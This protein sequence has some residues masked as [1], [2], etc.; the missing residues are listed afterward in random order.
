LAV[1]VVELKQVLAQRASGVAIVTAR[2]GDQ[3]HGMTV[4]AFAEVSLAPPLVLVCADKISH[5][6]SL[7]ARGGVFAL[8]VLAADQRALSDLFASKRDEERRF[9]GL[10]YDTGVTGAPLLRDTLATLACR[11]RAAHEA[12][13]HVIYVGEVL[14]CRRAQRDPLV[15]WRGAYRALTD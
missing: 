13:D 8:N 15:Y 5:T 10:D 4:S 2:A 9:V 14:D 1:D 11:V 3:I 12:G 6:H 7:I